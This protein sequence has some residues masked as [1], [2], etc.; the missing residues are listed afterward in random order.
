MTDQILSH[1]DDTMQARLDRLFEL[2]RIPSVSTDPAF[3]PDVARA[4]DWL[5][6]SVEEAKSQ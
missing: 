2:I 4:A 3:A 1:I 5:G 6:D